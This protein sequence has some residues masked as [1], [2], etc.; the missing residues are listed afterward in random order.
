MASIVGASRLA[1]ILTLDIKPFVRNTELAATKL[2]AFR[3]K[4][5]ALGSTLG[6]SLGVA[7]GLVGA[8][9]IR[10][11]AEFNKIESQLRAVGTG[12]NI[13][14]IVDKAKQLG[15]ETMF[16]AT[17]VLQLGL[18]LKKLGFDAQS[19]NQALETSV[20][21]TQ[22]FGGSLQQVGTSIAE[23]QRQF[24]G[25]NGELR[26]FSEI[27]DIFATAFAQSALDST[28]LAGALKNVGSVA[29]VA[30]YSIEETVALL[31]L[32]ANAG[33]KSGYAGTRLKGVFLE[34]GEEFGFTGKE[35]T[36][37]TS[38]NLDVAQT[39]EILHKRAGVAGAVIGKMGLEFYQLLVQLEDVD[40]ALDAMNEG[41]EDELFIQLEKNTN[42]LQTMGRVLGEALT[43]YVRILATALG[44][45]A[46]S[47]EK[48]DSNTKGMI[49]RFTILSV[50]IP[51][52]AA[53][54]AALAS[55]LIFMTAHPIILGI[56]ALTAA[57]VAFQ[58]QQYENKALLDSVNESLSSFQQLLKD[59]DGELTSLSLPVL[60]T[61]LEETQEALEAAAEAQRRLLF[62][63]KTGRRLSDEEAFL[64]V[65]KSQIGL[66][67]KIYRS[68][69]RTAELR[70][71]AA[72][73][74]ERIKT[75]DVDLREQILALEEAIADKEGLL[76]FEAQ[77]RYLLAQKTGDVLFSQQESFG[78]I[79][80]QS[81]KITEAFT[82]AF[83]TFGEA[84]NDLLGVKDAIEDILQASTE[85][86]I[87]EGLIGNI[88]KDFDA[89]LSTGSLD[90]QINLVEDLAD[91]F[92]K[93][94]TE[95]SSLN[96]PNTAADLDKFAA[97]FERK[98]KDLQFSK[99][100]RDAISGRTEANR[101]ASSLFD[102]ELI[103]F[104]EVLRR[105]ISSAKDLITELLSLGYSTTSERVK[106]LTKNI[107]ELQD[108]LAKLESEEALKKVLDEASRVSAQQAFTA[109]QFISGIGEV[110]LSDTLTGQVS[111]LEEQWKKLYDLLYPADPDQVPIGS[112]EQL[113][114][115]YNKWK[116]LAYR[117]NNEIKLEEFEQSLDALEKQDALTK[118]DA[119][120]GLIDKEG[121]RA[122]NISNL[123]AQIRLLA[124]APNGVNLVA[125]DQL[126]DKLQVL[127]EEARNV[128]NASS[129]ITFFNQQV[130]FLGEAFV[131]AAKDGANFWQTLKESF[132]NTFYALV[133][134]LITLITLYTI[135]LI[136]SGGTS[137]AA[138]AAGSAIEGGFGTFLAEGMTGL[139]LRSG[140]TASSSAA[141]AAGGTATAGVVRLGGSISGNDVVISNQRG[142][143]AIDRTFG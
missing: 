136:V 19:T 95:A 132:L 135:L 83:A 140:T 71:Q 18:E 87:S 125:F 51:V 105:E 10:V 55:A 100:L 59:T 106:D 70:Q 88:V 62:D 52:V 60:K 41:L 61:E 64:E 40:G 54:L 103:G 97:D 79:L 58:M 17:E 42:A 33:Q 93:L 29:N 11:S 38:G 1:A 130:S 92:K 37:L 34:L 111:K 3:M 120:L 72:T 109:Q 133:A 114:E 44:D 12:E 24:Q 22:I 91:E 107:D 32:L 134:K 113:D 75:A 46:E 57:F 69:E 80:D 31:G 50:L 73:E 63:S 25:A 143:R 45:L 123:T 4:A 124:S 115:V 117:L 137:A 39:F 82:N 26:S 131:A 23:T 9:A 108:K 78:V 112:Q 21:L 141:V 30:G 121:L 119:E 67:D 77:R 94:A 35:L 138:G 68:D 85:E 56:T 89:L 36:A 128:A 5:Q 81:Q 122:A 53:G 66:L 99:K 65:Y 47:F 15:I 96:L 110:K 90:S 43:P 2:E 101:E 139:N 49:A 13:D 20:K 74:L 86:I 27:G 14:G 7:L 126:T 48:A 6:R 127:Q 116:S 118:L 129:L 102:L 84:N 98:L 8:A 16:T 76:A 104:D 28:K 142:T